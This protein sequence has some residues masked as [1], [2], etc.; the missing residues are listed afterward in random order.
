MKHQVAQPNCCVYQFEQP[1]TLTPVILCLSGSHSN[2]LPNKKISRTC[3]P[4]WVLDYTFAPAYNMRIGNTR[5]PWQFREAR[6][7][8]L[9]PPKTAFWADRAS[10][11]GFISS[12]SILFEGGEDVGLKKLIAP[13]QAYAR[14]NDPEGK[15]GEVF[16]ELSQ[17]PKQF[18]DHCY[19]AVKSKLWDI[20]HM[21][22][23]AKH[24]G[25]EDYLVRDTHLPP[26]QTFTAQVEQFMREHYAEK[27]SLDTIAKAFRISTK[28]LT[29]RF[30]SENKSSPMARL[31]EIRI[32]VA[33]HLLMHGERTGEIAIKIGFSNEFHLSKTFKKVT[34]YSPRDFL[35]SLEQ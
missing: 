31:N 26:E 13:S 30:H 27:L 17:Q 8:H 12:A 6:Q 4:Y 22:L 28:T 33:K 34:G 7:C 2:P 14:F 23:M 29:R 32:D 11:K 18:G 15:L 3:L 24:I 20:F 35:K 25:N 10:A 16:V 5:K 9:Y 1:D 19:P 21:L